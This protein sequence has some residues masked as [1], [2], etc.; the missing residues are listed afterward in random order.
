MPSELLIRPATLSDWDGIWPFYSEI[1]RAGDTYCYDPATSY[2]EGR[3]GWLAPAPDETWVAETG[4]R[5][6]GSYHIGPNKA[7][8]GAH[9]ANGSYM[10][11]A[12]TRGT[13]VGRALVEH[14]L[15]RAREAGFRGIQ[16]NAVAATNV[17]AV[18]LYEQLGFDTIG[19]VPDG[20]HHPV[21]GF[22]DLLI[23]YRA[24]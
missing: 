14:S 15:W 10:V 7:G 21:E 8:P 12:E 18:K 3:R 19:R 5:I 2:D 1:V 20:F 17:Y 23:M 22:V 9:V 6:V 16:F 13:G 4:G 11:A 24:L